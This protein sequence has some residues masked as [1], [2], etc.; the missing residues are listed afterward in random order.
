[1]HSICAVNSQEGIKYT[2][3]KGQLISKCP[4]GIFKSPKKQASK[5]R[6]NQKD[7]GTL[8]RQLEDFILTLLN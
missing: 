3:A 8:Y 1:M 6:S 7:K 2:K 5:K 4:F